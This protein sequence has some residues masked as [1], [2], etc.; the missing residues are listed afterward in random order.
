MAQEYYFVSDLHIGGDGDLREC[1]FED[2][3]IEFLASFET[4][5]PDTEL[6]IVGDSFGLWEFTEVEG[7]AKLEAL[8]RQ[9]RRLFDQFRAIGARIRVTIIPGNHDYELAC[10]PE[11]IE[12][13]RDFNIIL[14]PSVSITRR[15]GDKKI[16]IEHG[17]QHD[18]HNVMPDFGN[19]HANPLGFFMTRHIVATA[20]KHSSLGRY[21]WLKDV[22]SVSP[23]EAV[24]HWMMSNYFYREMHLILRLTLVPFLVLFSVSV[25]ALIGSLL[26][27]FGLLA[28]TIFSDNQIFRRLGFVGDVLDAIIMVNGI[29]ILFLLPLLIPLWIFRRDIMQTLERFQILPDEEFV[30]EKESV[31]LEVARNVFERHPDV[32]VYLFGHTHHAYIK[33]IDGGTVINT[34]TWLKQLTRVPS[35]FWLLPDVYY[36]HYSLNYFVIKEEGG[37][38]VVDYHVV[39]REAPAELS[40]LQRFVIFGRA[41]KLGKVIPTRTVID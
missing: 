23:L 36:P 8:I 21:N 24:P 12:R 34:G 6:L 31:F 30:L 39:P 10:F 33:K 19:P 41:K 17:M 25:L 27:D 37:Q 11:F 1:S 13:L 14:E 29:I 7:M 35:R 28:T 4:K 20:G 38:A 2:E 26:E 16:W 5:G 15:L 22:Q 32:C 18:E 40:P 3:F 9:Q